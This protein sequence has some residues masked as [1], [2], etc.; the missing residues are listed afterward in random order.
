MV[1]EQGQEWADKGMAQ[2]VWQELQVSS[3]LS[4]TSSHGGEGTVMEDAQGQQ[5]GE[6]TKQV[7]LPIWDSRW[8]MQEEVSQ[9]R[10]PVK[11]YRI[12]SVSHKAD[13]RR[14]HAPGSQD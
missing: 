14:G 7:L 13:Q 1:L 2:R 4:R 6:E 8:Q 11:D 9:V 12:Q 5:K 10:T 3:L